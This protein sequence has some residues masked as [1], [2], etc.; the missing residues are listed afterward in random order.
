LYKYGNWGFEIRG[1]QSRIL[2]CC[3]KMSMD[4]VDEIMASP[5]TQHHHQKKYKY[6]F[7]Q[8][9]QLVKY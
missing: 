3:G 2:S 9:V 4:K 6:N 5:A 1:Q 8:T 7:R